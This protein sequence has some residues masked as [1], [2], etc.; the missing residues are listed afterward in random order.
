MQPDNSEFQRLPFDHCALSLQPFEN[1]YC[2]V[3]GN[4]FELTALVPFLKKFKV[5]PITG[6]KMD[7]KSLIKLKFF[8][9]AE[10][11]YHC[12]VL[13]KQFTANSHIVC[14]RTTGNIFSYEVFH[15]IISLH[16]SLL[17]CSFWH[18]MA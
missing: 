18:D 12:P 7:V 10:E 13:Y 9:N 4:I 6:E 14:I 8:K 5:N 15:S 16:F 1:P 11:K 17:N 3:H 2:D